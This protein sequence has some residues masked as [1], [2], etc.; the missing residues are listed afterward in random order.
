MT[1]S[2]LLLVA[3]FIV[4]VLASIPVVVSR[5]NLIALGLALWT[6]SELLAGRLLLH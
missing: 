5:V 1:I 2:L 6:L 3:A 4:F